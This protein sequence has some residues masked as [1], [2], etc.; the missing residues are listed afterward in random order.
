MSFSAVISAANTVQDQLFSA[1]RL[2]AKHCKKEN[3][4]SVAETVI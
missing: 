3:T 1:I 2:H 4:T